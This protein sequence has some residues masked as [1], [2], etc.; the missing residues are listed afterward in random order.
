MVKKKE[1]E[2]T[3]VQIRRETVRRLKAAILNEPILKGPPRWTTRDLVDFLVAEGLA[4]IGHTLES[5]SSYW[6]QRVREHEDDLARLPKGGD[7]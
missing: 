1:G 4:D 2:Y 7:R 3:S 5:S 6:R